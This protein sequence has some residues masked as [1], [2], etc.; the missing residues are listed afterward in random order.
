MISEII[1]LD[2]DQWILKNP[3]NGLDN[4]LSSWNE[5][6]Q[7]A[8]DFFNWVS[9]L[10]SLVESQT[11]SNI[12]DIQK[13]EMLYDSL[14]LDFSSIKEADFEVNSAKASPWRVK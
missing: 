9:D 10:R 1:A 2:N 3:A 6:T 14:H 8:K 11:S 7:V 4:I 5:E 12:E 13:S